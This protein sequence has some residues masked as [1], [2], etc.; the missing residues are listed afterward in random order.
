[1]TTSKRQIA[2]TVVSGG[3]LLFLYSLIFSFSAQDGDESGSLSRMISEKC[4]E[5]FNQLAN[6]NWSE[7]VIESFA[8]YFEHPIRKLAHFAEYAC[9]GILVYVLWVQWIS[10]GKKLYLL[11]VI[12]VFVSAAA[13]ELHQLFVPGRYGCFADVLLDTAGGMFGMFMCL[14][15]GKWFEKHKKVTMFERA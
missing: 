8:E 10:K 3:L 11:T 6:R 13:D 14:W 1:M 9:M 15:I 7:A 5:L 4:V 2:V 12:W